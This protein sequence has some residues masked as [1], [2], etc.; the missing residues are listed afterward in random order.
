[1]FA[2]RMEV[3]ILHCGELAQQV[4]LD[5]INSTPA[6]SAA[7][8]INGLELLSRVDRVLYNQEN[9]KSRTTLVKFLKPQN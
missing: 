7:G 6:L 2:D 8:G 1:M 3:S 4:G 9:D 5:R